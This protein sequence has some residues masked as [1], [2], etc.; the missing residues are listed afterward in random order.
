MVTELQSI[1]SLVGTPRAVIVVSAHWEAKAIS[2]TGSSAPSLY[3]DYY[4]FP[5]EAYEVE[6]PCP[7][8]PTLAN[9]IVEVMAA[10]NIPA[11]IDSERGLDHG[12]FVPLKIMYPEANIPVVQLSLNTSLDPLVHLSIGKALQHLNQANVLILG[13]GFSFHNIQK[14]LSPVSNET[15]DANKAFEDWLQASV[16]ENNA[17][18]PVDQLHKW[19]NAPF[20][21]Y[22]HPREE[23]LLPLHVCVGLSE[24]KASYYHRIDIMGIQSSFFGWQI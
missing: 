14:L 4:N 7:G 22:C 16:N 18:D 12:V 13:S 1:A 24:R 17:L 8:N 3:F 23:H 10:D 9:E 2:V 21:E 20:A 5:P 19:R 15:P 6:Y 11:S